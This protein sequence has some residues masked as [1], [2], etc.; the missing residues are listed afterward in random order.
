MKIPNNGPNSRGGQINP[1]LQN[2]LFIDLSNDERL[3]DANKMLFSL[4]SISDV[5][6]MN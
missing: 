2:I 6:L 1:L 4:I 5:I 3:K